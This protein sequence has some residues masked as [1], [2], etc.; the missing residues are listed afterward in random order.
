MGS[1]I[2]VGSATCWFLSSC[3]RTCPGIPEFPPFLILEF[4][5]PGFIYLFIICVGM[6]ICVWVWLWCV[7][8]CICHSVHVGVRGQLSGVDSLLYSGIWGSNLSHMAYKCFYL[9]NHL[10]SPPLILFLRLIF[11]HWILPVI[12]GFSHKLKILPEMPDSGLNLEIFYTRNFL[13]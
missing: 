12:F 3:S 6:Y 9:Q 7:W 1:F 13:H 8:V 2:V 5:K 10:V 4:S 11:L